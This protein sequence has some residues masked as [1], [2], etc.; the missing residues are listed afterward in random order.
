MKDQD[1]VAQSQT[2]VPRAGGNTILEGL[3]RY[4]VYVNCHHIDGHE[5]IAE[6]DGEYIK[7]EDARAAVTAHLAGQSQATKVQAVPEGWKLVPV[8]PTDAM[9]DAMHD[10]IRILCVP[11]EKRADIQNDRF[12]WSVMLA[13]APQAPTAQEVTQQAAKAGDYEPVWNEDFPTGSC[14]TCGF[15]EKKHGC[16]CP[17]VIPSLAP[18]TSTVSASDEIRNAALEEAADACKPGLIQ[19]ATAYE[20][21]AIRKC[22]E[23]IRSLRTTST[24]K[25]EAA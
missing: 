6:P 21:S 11:A 8:E 17:P 23:A 19:S 4:T 18:T 5:I 25:G 22:A 13:A 2:P 15:P 16:T 10:R 7:Y 9:L 12:V 24:N 1:K 14:P 3:E 20:I